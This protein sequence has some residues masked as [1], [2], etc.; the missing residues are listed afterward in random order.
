MRAE[1]IKLLVAL[2]SLALVFYTVRQLRR[3]RSRP[4][5]QPYPY[6]S[7]LLGAHFHQDCYDDGECDEDI[8]RAF[9][10]EGPAHELL[11][12]R[13]DIQRLLAEERGQLRDAVERLFAPQITL[14]EDDAQ[15]EAWLLRADRLLAEC[16]EEPPVVLP[17]DGVLDLHGFAPRDVKSLVPEWIDV[18]RAHGLRELR[19]VHGKGRGS[20]RR[21]VHALLARRSDVLSYRLAP[22]ERGGWG[23]TLITLRDPT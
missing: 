1:L 18:C 6:L 17:L 22:A 4:G 19:I 23:A 11:G 10:R 12:A 8:L 21:S 13:A 15:I 9:A 14:G 2:L 16:T 7:Q 20:L 5:D 3:G